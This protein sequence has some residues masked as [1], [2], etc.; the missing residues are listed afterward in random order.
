[1][2]NGAYLLG[3]FIGPT[4]YGF[5][6]DS[7]GFRGATMTFLPILALALIGNICELLT[8]LVKGRQ[9]KKLVPYRGIYNHISE[10]TEPLF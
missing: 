10:E 8:G 1:M 2:W 7:I 6:V 4:A 9:E 5:V 3:C